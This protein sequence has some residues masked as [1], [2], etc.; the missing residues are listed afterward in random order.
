LET[1]CRDWF[2][3]SENN[4]S[5]VE[6]KERCGAPKKLEDEELKAF[7]EDSWQTLDELA[8]L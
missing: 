7:H 2:R 4:D 5:H 1:I 8:E 6:G 3:R